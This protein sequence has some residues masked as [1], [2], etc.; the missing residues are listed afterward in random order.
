VFQ[1]SYA[2]H[3][4]PTKYGDRTVRNLSDELLKSGHNFTMSTFTSRETPETAQL[5]KNY[6]LKWRRGL[7]RR[8]G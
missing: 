7:I 2:C 6:I 4:S 8:C 1:I 3:F 5:R